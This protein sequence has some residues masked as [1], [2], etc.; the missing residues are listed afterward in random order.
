[1]QDPA[2]DFDAIVLGNEG[3]LQGTI[4]E[5]RLYIRMQITSRHEGAHDS[6]A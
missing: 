5:F 2:S 1:M 3:P 4:K 6:A